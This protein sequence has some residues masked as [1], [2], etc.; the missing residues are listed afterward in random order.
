M[1]KSSAE[2]REGST[3]DRMMIRECVHRQRISIYEPATIKDISIEVLGKALTYLLPCRLNLVPT[4]LVCRSWHALARRLLNCKLR[5]D[6][7][8][9]VQ[10]L[11]GL[12]LKSICLGAQASK[13]LYLDL[14][15]K[16]GIGDIAL[17]TLARLVSPFLYIL[18]INFHGM[19]FGYQKL[20]G[21]G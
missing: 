4:T 8:Y 18:R 3:R 17:H 16:K 10:R 14:D 6:E 13:I 12:Q 7:R 1:V 20:E 9:I 15:M 19:S 11:C 5:I 21:M 2:L